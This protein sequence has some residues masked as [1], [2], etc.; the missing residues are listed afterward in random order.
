M[1]F[2]FFYWN[3]ILVGLRNF[4]RS[5]VQSFP[6]GIKILTE[7]FGFH[8]DSTGNLHKD[9]E[10]LIKRRLIDI[11]NMNWGYFE[12]ACRISCSGPVHRLK[13]RHLGTAGMQQC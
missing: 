4:Q 8:T 7:C 12:T 10:H 9:I 2:F 1:I 11:L 5:L 13:Q 6:Q 3:A